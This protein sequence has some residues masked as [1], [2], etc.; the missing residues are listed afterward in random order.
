MRYRLVKLLVLMAALWL[1]SLCAAGDADGGWDYLCKPELREGVK[2]VV[3]FGNGVET[4]PR[5]ALVYTMMLKDKVAEK[6]KA[7]GAPEAVD[8]MEFCVAAAS[9]SGAVLYKWSEGDPALTAADFTRYD[10]DLRANIATHANEWYDKW[11]SEGKRV[12]VVAHSNGN[13]IANEAYR[14]VQDELQNPNIG[15]L[16][17][18]AVGTPDDHVGGRPASDYI[19]LYGDRSTAVAGSRPP[20][21]TESAPASCPEDAE[22]GD[23]C[24]DFPNAYLRGDLTGPAIIDAIVGYV[25]TGE[26]GIEPPY[27]APPDTTAP[28]VPE[29]LTATASADYVYLAWARAEDEES[30]VAGYEVLR[31]GALLRTVTT[32]YY[33]DIKLEASTTYCYTVAA[34]DNAKN[35]SG[36]SN[37]MCVT[38]PAV[39]NVSVAITPG[40]ASGTVGEK[41][42][43]EVT[44]QNTD[45][46][47]ATDPATGAGCAK[48]AG[49]DVVECA[50]TK[51][52]VYTVTV[53]A[54]GDATQ[55]DEAEFEVTLAEPTIALSPK[56]ATVA[57]SQT[58]R[59]TADVTTPV[60][61]PTQTPVWTVVEADCGSVVNDGYDPGTGLY[62][63]VY[64]SPAAE[65]GCTVQASI[66]DI[67]GTA[68]T[69]TAAVTVEI[70]AD[71]IIVQG[72]PM[73]YVE[74]GEFMMGCDKETEG[75]SCSSYSQPKHPV[76]LTK[77]FY[78]G[79]TEVTR[80][81]WQAIMGAS[82]TPWTQVWD[83]KITKP[84]P[85][86]V[87]RNR[88]PATGVGWT[89]VHAFIDK[90]NELDAGNGRTWR[91]PWEAEWEWAARGGVKS[92]SCVKDDNGVTTPYSCGVIRYSGAYQDDGIT[93]DTNSPKNVGWDANN[94]GYDPTAPYYAQQPHE[95]GLKL[96]N[97]LDVYDMAGNVGEWVE[98][99]WEKTYE[100]YSTTEPAVDPTGP[101]DGGEYDRGLYRGGSWA[102][103]SLDMTVYSGRTPIGRTLIDGEGI[104]DRI[105][106]R[107]VFSMGQGSPS[108]GTPDDTETV[109]IA[110]SPNPATVLV[111]EPATFD[112]TVEHA[113]DKTFTVSASSKA[114][115]VVDGSKV[116]CTPT[117]S[118]EYTVTVKAVADTG[119]TAKATLTANDPV[120][121]TISG[122][123]S[124]A[125]G[126][127]ASFN[128]TVANAADKGFTVSAPAGA[129]CPASGTSGTPL[130]CVPTASGSHTIEVTAKADTSKKNSATLTASYPVS[131]DIA[132]K[133]ASAV[134]GET[135]AT[136]TVTVGNATDTGFSFSVPSG[137]GCSKSGSTLVCS[138]L[139]AGTYTVT[140]TSDAD[141]TKEAE[142]TLNVKAPVSI[143]FASSPTATA[144]A[145]ETEAKFTVAVSNAANTGFGITVDAGAGCPGSGV[146]GTEFSCSPTVANLSGYAIKVTSTEDPTKT[147]TTTLYVKDAVVIGFT[148]KSQGMALG[149]TSAIFDVTVSNYA[150]DTGFSLSAP[151]EAGCDIDGSRVVCTP[152]AT[153]TYTITV[154]SNEESR[155]DTATLTVTLDDALITIASGD[156][157][158]V[159]KGKTLPFKASVTL[160]QGQS[161]T[162]GPTWT[163]EEA[164]CGNVVDDGYNPGT[165]LAS[166][167]SSGTYN[168]TYTAP[169]TVGSC[170]VKVSFKDANG[171]EVSDEA[172]VEVTEPP[173][174]M[175][176]SGI[177]MHYVEH[178]EFMMGCNTGGSANGANGTYVNANG[179]TTNLNLTTSACSASSRPRH[180]VKL[181]K[182]FYI[183]QTEVTQAQ[184]KA[185]M[186][187]DD[188]PWTATWTATGFN[189]SKIPSGWD[190]N[191]LPAS[192]ISWQKANEFIAK[193]NATE[194]YAV[195]GMKWALPTEAQWEWAARGG[196]KSKSC[197]Y[198][199]DGKLIPYTCGVIRWIGAY[200]IDQTTCQITAVPDIDGTYKYMS[201]SSDNATK[202]LDIATTIV[203]QP[204]PVGKDKN[205]YSK[206]PYAGC[207]GVDDYIDSRNELLLYD[208]S[209]NV[210]EWVADAYSSTYNSYST[211]TDAPTVDPLNLD[212]GVYGLVRGGSFKITADTAYGDRGTTNARAERS[213][214]KDIFGLRLV[215]VE[216]SE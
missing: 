22:P 35:R 179:V 16:H 80:A 209:G 146:G 188:T 102:Q 141:P 184:W 79:K 137:A 57:P 164:D 9:T 8:A 174:T 56:K 193:L 27:V 66:L 157:A 24:H 6:Y 176:V 204:H 126:E 71:E 113:A 110:I 195:P 181:T 189:S 58:V 30:G 114:G 105:G 15:N 169:A 202:D 194:A 192:A 101:S 143:A 108:D 128:V 2:T 163:V 167:A 162:E 138:P 125:V 173:E 52:G 32:L 19:T 186:G 59:F 61:Q 36:A 119:K 145:N 104:S 121:I 171:T 106:L 161:I 83:E 39:L 49:E 48:K 178:G 75:N 68:I 1:P 46:T 111:N 123:T 154:T 107:L 203:A 130:V 99:W 47:V 70:P 64:T 21:F 198:D 65:K 152:T 41:T 18:L 63:A 20:N 93:P 23:E 17:I 124:V 199:S 185:V 133:T 96:P 103:S 213:T 183:G 197:Q 150:T 206:L 191:Q 90:L 55:T 14:I 180:P 28:T 88:L 84:I 187:E 13:Y 40:Y 175:T 51:P 144:I 12:V 115:C 168:A 116:V 158:T 97:E 94:S 118:G 142:A 42:A 60:G 216:A 131:I 72:I 153:G 147:A 120:S 215:L 207:V 69:A 33:S 50:P 100:R 73:R 211:D 210:A 148:S 89:A 139:A 81:Q 85:E 134:V 127:D 67:E 29:L 34:F 4:T 37:E 135:S 208:M 95:V 122:T 109:T 11:L 190:Q 149:G 140:V 78:I 26:P 77:D 91:L 160:P 132:P 92:K 98:D 62:A 196:V 45:F 43:F 25:E 214:I 200:A 112:V 155:T 5:E 156:T 165:D 38:T 212:D 74:H 170:T 87:D 86:G 151:S 201:W 76:K 172:T 7:L 205:I 177:T 166:T 53:T 31:D 54:T 136:F 129:G 3:L 44:A 82:D 117:A 159:V 10:K 182:D